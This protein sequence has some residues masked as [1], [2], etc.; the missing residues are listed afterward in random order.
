MIGILKIGPI[1]A[2]SVS[3]RYLIGIGKFFI[4]TDFLYRFQ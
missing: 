1:M 3:D 4:I 2:L